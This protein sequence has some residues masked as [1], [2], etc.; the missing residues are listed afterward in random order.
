MWTF[1]GE[2]TH[3]L[4]VLKLDVQVVQ[5]DW[6]SEYKSCIPLNRWFYV[7]EGDRKKPTILLAHGFPSQ[8]RHT[9]ASSVISM[10]MS[11]MWHISSLGGSNVIGWGITVSFANL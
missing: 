10:R 8:V 6:K 9:F 1:W 7:E 3:L 11:S 5:Y 4:E 2:I